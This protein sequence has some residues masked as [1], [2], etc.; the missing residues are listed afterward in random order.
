[1]KEHTRLMEQ[2]IGIAAFERGCTAPSQRGRILLKTDPYQ[3]P[4]G[5]IQNLSPEKRALLQGLTAEDLNKHRM[6]FVLI[7]TPVE[8]TFESFLKTQRNRYK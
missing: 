4:G 7:W 3:R 2:L 5:M 6:D 1:M 8:E